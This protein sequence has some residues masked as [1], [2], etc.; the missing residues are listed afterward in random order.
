MTSVRE[1][2]RERERDIERITKQINAKVRWHVSV[3]KDR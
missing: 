3:D 2:E 1:R